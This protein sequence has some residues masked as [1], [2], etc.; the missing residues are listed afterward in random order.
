MMLRGRELVEARAIAEEAESKEAGL[1][2]SKFRNL[3]MR[4]VLSGKELPP[5]TTAST[6]SHDIGDSSVVKQADIP[7]HGSVKPLTFFGTA[8]PKATEVDAGTARLD[9]SSPSKFEESV[10]QAQEKLATKMAEKTTASQGGPMPTSSAID[11][12]SRINLMQR[13]HN[14]L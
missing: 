5:P 1:A 11:V 13:R 4:M 2:L 8:S 3:G 14:I 12:L 6:V 10:R 9:F 7:L